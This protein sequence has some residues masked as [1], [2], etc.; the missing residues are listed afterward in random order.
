MNTTIKC[1]LAFVAGAAIGVAAAWKILEA[2]YEKFAQEEIDS[3]KETLLNRNKESKPEEK[4]S[5]DIQK[6]VTTS[7]SSLDGYHKPDNKENVDYA[8]IRTSDVAK[9]MADVEKPCVIPPDEFGEYY[10]YDTINLTHYSDGVLTDENDEV[11][12]DV[13]GAVGADYAD[14]FGEYEDDEDAVHIRNDVRKCYYEILRDYRNYS[15]VVGSNP[16]QMEG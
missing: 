16:H 13:E 15:D 1:S 2:K 10:D 6:P 3:V 5:D 7:R 12:D 9:K 14:H 8:S 11:V 4:E